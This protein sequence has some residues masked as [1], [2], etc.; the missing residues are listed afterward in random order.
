MFAGEAYV[1]SKECIAQWPNNNTIVQN[2]FTFT[3]ST[4][5]HPALVF[6][7]N[8]YYGDK[9]LLLRQT[10]VNVA[11]TTILTLPADQI[12]IT[13]GIDP[14][15]GK[16]LISTTNTLNMSATLSTVSRIHWYG[17]VSNELLKTIEVDD[18]ILGF[19][20]VGGTVFV[21]YGQKL[22]YITGSGISFLRTLQNVSLTQTF[23]P[24]K[25]NFAN[26][27]N[28]LY[29]VDGTQ[30]LAF[31]EIL[32]GNKIFYYAVKNKINSNVIQSIFNAGNN[33]LGMGFATTKFY[34]VDFSSIA[35]LDGLSLMTNWY[36]FPRPITPRGMRM[37]YIDSVAST[38]NLSVTYFD[39][40]STTAIAA[41]TRSSG[42]RTSTLEIDD[43]I[44]FLNTYPIY[45]LKF[46]IS[47]AT[48]NN[49]LK[50]IIVYYDYAE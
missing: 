46:L 30:V 1:T 40:T 12:I 43:M 49:G 8:A 26:I 32:R 31:G 38:V 14:G 36:N 27:G 37:E 28:T 29:V 2:W 19:Y 10:G 25:H 48:T 47:N 4:V 34:T 21:G 44:G 6:E 41:L 3:T 17:G 35:T 16:M 33:K 15:T 18:T 50:R 5:P 9:N 45:A 13:L 7:K 11:P 24:Y 39:Q 20:P 23:L 22:G 42:T